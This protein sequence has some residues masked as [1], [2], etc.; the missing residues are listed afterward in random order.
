MTILTLCAAAL[1]YDSDPQAVVLEDE[2]PV[3]QNIAF[4]TGVVPSG[5]PVGVQFDLGTN[6][7]T[8]VRMAGDASLSWPDDVT[9]AAVGTPGEGLFELSASLD[10]ITSVVVDLSSYGGPSGSFEIDHRSLAMD[11]R[12]F[13]DP[14]ALD[15]S[16]E[17]RVEI[18]DT[19]DSTQLIQ[20]SYEIFSGVS[21]DF[22]ADM[23]PTITVGFEG[24]QWLANEGVITTENTPVVITPEQG[25]DFVVDSIFRGAYDGTISLVFTPQVSITA[26]FLGSIP[27]VSFDYP[28]DLVTDS[29]E[30][31]FATIKSVFPMPV[32]QPGI[33]A[34]DFGDV[35]IGQ[36]ATLEVPMQN[37][38]NLALEGT[39]S[40]EGEAVYTVYPDQFNA[41]PS[42]ADGLVITFAPEEVGEFSGELVLTS[43]DPAYP[44]MR[45]PL[46][47]NGVQSDVGSDVGK[48]TVSASLDGCGCQSGSESAM[49]GL[50]LGIAG[51]TLAARRRG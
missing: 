10:A 18:V 50:I 24:V 22:Q 7:G 2:A 47:G 9:F 43:N 34:A 32:L 29:F 17:P 27:L 46:S 11:G 33:D 15:G 48:D 49:P 8:T 36:I 20:Y 40:I 38:G 12:E 6:G 30:Q 21:L 26:P 31:D 5:S 28:L 14:F 51:L 13:F 41:N 39:A 16:S 19:T 25:A 23:T 3:F 37:V 4:S 44:D 35:E 45:I 42:T 1:A